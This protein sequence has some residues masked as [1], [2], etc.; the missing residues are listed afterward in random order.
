LQM[1]ELW[2]LMQQFLN[3]HKDVTNASVC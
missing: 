2:F 3:F 1:Q